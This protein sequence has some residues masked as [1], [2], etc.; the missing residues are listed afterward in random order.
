MLGDFGLVNKNG[1]TPI[2]CAPEQLS[3]DAVQSTDVHGLGITIL[4]SYFEISSGLQLLF[5]SPKDANQ[6]G[7]KLLRNDPVFRLVEEMIRPNPKKRLSIKSIQYRLDV[8]RYLLPVSYRKTG[9]ILKFPKKYFTHSNTLNQSFNTASLSCT[10]PSIDISTSISLVNISSDVRDQGNTYY[11]W[12]FSISSILKSELIKLLK[13]LNSKNK[14]TKQKMD[15]LVSIAGDLNKNEQ[16]V[17]ELV[18]L[19]IPRKLKFK[20]SGDTLRQQASTV[21]GAMEKICYESIIM[22]P[23]WKRL[24]SITAITDELPGKSDISYRIYVTQ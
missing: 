11:C 10:L 6:A 8:L 7:L 23:G 14:L 13:K 15:L 9:K 12:A 5:G 24:P 22:E 19:V 16:L 3:N 21:K 17:K 18:C 20:A 1:V 4:L 2:F